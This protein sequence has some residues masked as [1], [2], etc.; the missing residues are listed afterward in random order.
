MRLKV[1]GFK[2]AGDKG[3]SIPKLKFENLKVSLGLSCRVT[4]VYDDIKAQ[5]TCKTFNLKLLSF[6]GPY[7]IT[8]GIVGA[9]LSLV[10][11]LIKSSILEQLPVELGQFIRTLPMPCHLDGEFDV[12]GTQLD[13]LSEIMH[14]SHVVQELCGYS[15]TQIEMFFALQKAMERSHILKTMSDLLAYQKSFAH[16][17]VGFSAVIHLWDQAATMY[18]AKVIDGIG[19]NT[20][21]QLSRLYPSDLTILFEP[22]MDAC[23][24]LQR[25]RIVA[26]FEMYQVDGQLSLNDAFKYAHQFIH[27]IS[28]EALEKAN[29]L[30]KSQLLATIHRLGIVYAEMLG[31]LQLISQN[32]DFAQWKVQASLRTGPD[33]LLKMSV[34]E[35]LAQLPILLNLSISKPKTM[36]SVPL[37]PF[38]ISFKPQPNGDIYLEINSFAHKDVPSN[39]SSSGAIDY[40]KHLK[41]IIAQTEYE[42][43]SKP[44][45]PIIDESTLS[46]SQCDAP[47]NMNMIL[48]V[49]A[50]SPQ[51]SIV[52]DRNVRLKAGAELFTLAIGPRNKGWRP[53]GTDAIP[54]GIEEE[55]KKAEPPHD[56]DSNNNNDA[57]ESA[58]DIESTGKAE[59]DLSPEEAGCPISIQTGPGIRMLA[60]IPNAAVDLHLGGLTRF[61]LEHFEDLQLLK[62]YLEA[63]FGGEFHYEELNLTRLIL[64][65]LSKYVHMPD[66]S[67]DINVNGKIV[68]LEREI[69]VRLET[70]IEVIDAR[71]SMRNGFSI[72]RPQRGPEDTSAVKV[73]IDI[74]IR[75]VFEDFCEILTYFRN[76]GA[77]YA[78]AP[79]SNPTFPPPPEKAEGAS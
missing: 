74:N 75:D 73:M 41:S 50:T 5:W 76:M 3:K 7:G 47:A 46:S 32:L 39:K 52:V 24:K 34:K 35:I 63:V 30:Q 59:T 18:S 57:D 79:E 78:T 44:L 4:F 43:I 38:I 58:S 27:R 72:G 60:Q 36:G 71:D 42:R 23:D 6:K 45:S 17:P 51:I 14:H 26:N 66:C 20:L 56:N 16:D 10:T 77:D 28:T 31:L 19:E 15:S 9:I 21:S 70:P 1:E 48:C 40:N 67:A 37:I 8:R 11:P 54:E 25:K 2:L 29:A 55:A 53:F 12:A 33:G 64:Q 69:L 13:L 61:V 22:F 62:E 49:N 68:A 65:K